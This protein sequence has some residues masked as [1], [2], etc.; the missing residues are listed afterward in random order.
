M[1]ELSWDILY[2]PA[3]ARRE[4][5]EPEP[6]RLV[7]LRSWEAWL[8]LSLLLL[9]HLP[10]VGSLESTHWVREMPSLVIASLVGVVS[11][12][13]LASIRARALWLHAIGIPFGLAVVLA[14]VMQAMRLSDPLVE[15]GVRARWS[16]LWLRLGEWVEAAVTGATSSDPIPFVLLLV[17]LVWAMAYVSAWAVVRWQ[18][19]W[20]AVV[21][22]GF[23]LLTNISY[24]P[25]QPS[26]S[27]IVFLFAAVLIVARM[28]Y[29]Q[30]AIRWRNE[31]V[32]LPDFMSLEVL[33]A[34]VWVGLILILAAWF[35][36]TANDWG[37]IADR[38]IALV[39]PVNDRLDRIGRLFVG[40]SS[41]KPLPAHAFGDTLPLRGKLSL[42]ST[43]LMEVT[44]PTAANL[45]GAV[46]DRYT[47]NGWRVSS[48]SRVPLLGTSVDAAQF[49]T[50]LT[51]TQ[52]RQAVPITVKVVGE[53]PDRRLLSA[54]DPLATSVDA[55]ALAGATLQDLIGLVPGKRV[56]P[57]IGYRTAGTISV[58]AVPTLLTSGRDYPPEILQRYTQLPDGL[59]PQIATLARS[60][61]GNAQQPYEVARRV[62]QYLRDNYLYDLTVLDPPPLRDAVD[63]FLFD[64]KRGYFDYHASA[65]A[66]LL[67]TLGIPTRIATGFALDD[68]DLNSATKA[69]EVSELRA[70]AWPEVY[71]V[72]LGWVEFNPTPTRPPVA[73]PLD[74]AALLRARDAAGGVGLGEEFEALLLSE[75]EVDNR[76]TVGWPNAAGREGL[77]MLGALVVRLLTLLVMLGVVL[78]V[79]GVAG[80]LTWEWEFRGLTP[81][82]RRWGKVQRLAG[83]AGLG[84][85][86]TRTPI[87]STRDLATAVDGPAGLRRLAASFTAERYGGRPRE[88]SEE[89]ARELE[90]DYRRVR[91]TLVRLLAR[92]VIPWRRRRD[93]T[94]AGSAL[95]GAPTPRR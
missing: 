32:N 43:M 5:G 39:Q 23:V 67:R 57:G 27:F 84:S 55:E 52:V 25:G 47:G 20:A 8:T 70:W 73:R 50:P 83:W 74:D 77:G 34:G 35:I 94:R 64:S 16:E 15:S 54:G 24:L 72:G 13:V 76:A 68:A 26:F 87:E 58:A 37:P 46:Y 41:K 75:I 6:S 92:R 90:D 89:Q 95:R 22:G 1:A 7:F 17:M 4:E 30:A 36:P 10:V 60:I 91:T 40:I 82:V 14:E 2:R 33:F 88:E 11:G 19:A 29:L 79:L 3:G 78:L 85:R 42:S 38:W 61:A 49:G 62:E 56:Q 81:G 18:N 59:P 51:R 71:F 21:P 31:R 9:V 63:Y 45:R 44:A 53:M 65:M 66:V 86:A 48:A 28:H 12:W 69:Y 80:R 93:A